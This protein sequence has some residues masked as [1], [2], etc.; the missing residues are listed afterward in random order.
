MVSRVEC[1]CGKTLR[2][3]NRLLG[4]KARCPFCSAAIAIPI[5]CGGSSTR[6][7]DKMG[8]HTYPPQDLFECVIQSVVGIVCS[9][10]SGSGVFV[11]ANGTIATNRHIVGSDCVVTVKLNNTIE[12]A[13]KVMRSYRDID[14]AFVKV[15]FKPDKFAA[16]GTGNKAKV[17]QTVFAIGHPFGLQNTFT[18]GIISSVGRLIKGSYY[19]QTDAS[20]NP[21]N[22]GGPLFNEFAELIGINTM[23]IRESQ[24]LGFAIPAGSICKKYQEIKSNLESDVERFYCGVC[25]DNSSKGGYCENCGAQI[26]SEMTQRERI[27]TNQDDKAKSSNCRNCGADIEASGGFCVNC[28][29]KL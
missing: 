23:G 4:K 3:P 5:E 28:G 12:H 15:G 26:N 13:G 27:P 24:G 2:V 11:D 22:S 8:K 16:L 10:R 19:I 18:K 1:P 17:G 7:G 20:I 9:G 14:L 21:G 6:D 29:S 25:G